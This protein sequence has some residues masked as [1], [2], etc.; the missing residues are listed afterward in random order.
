MLAVRLQ[1]YLQ[2]EAYTSGN[3]PY[4]VRLE[5][6][7]SFDFHYSCRRLPFG[8]SKAPPAFRPILQTVLF[9]SDYFDE[10]KKGGLIM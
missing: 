8:L 5:N 1:P 9:K 6:N 3:S 7:E 4:G 2:R 10:S